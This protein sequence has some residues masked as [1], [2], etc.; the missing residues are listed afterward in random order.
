MMHLNIMLNI[1]RP[2]STVPLNILFSHRFPRMAC[3][4]LSEFYINPF[5]RGLW[6]TRVLSEMKFETQ[7]EKSLKLGSRL[8]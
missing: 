4:Y 6:S 2:F 7:E 3:F 1:G 8:L 5:H